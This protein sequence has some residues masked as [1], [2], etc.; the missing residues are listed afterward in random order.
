MKP[1][2]AGWKTA[3][4]T[5]P[6]H[7]PDFSG[8]GVREI[9]EVEVPV[10]EDESG[11]IYLSAEAEAILEAVK[12]RHMGLLSPKDLLELRRHLGLTQ[13]DMASLLQLGEKT[14]TRWETGRERPSRSLNLLLQALFDSRLDVTYLQSWTPGAVKPRPARPIRE[15]NS[16]RRLRTWEFAAALTK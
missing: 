15:P 2:V 6:V 8:E 1:P 11:E 9:V 3:Q 4:Q 13:R 5:V 14:W 10:W 7:I 12:A 16:P